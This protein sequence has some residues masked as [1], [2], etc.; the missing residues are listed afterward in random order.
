MRSLNAMLK[1]L[2]DTLLELTSNAVFAGD[3][4]ADFVHGLS[5]PDPVSSDPA[6]YH[7]GTF[8]HTDGSRYLMVVNRRCRSSD[9]RT[10]TV[11]LDARQLSGT[12][13]VYRMTDVYNN[14][15]V[16]ASLGT[17]GW[18]HSFSVSLDPGAGKLYRI[19]PMQLPSA[20]QNLTVAEVGDGTVTLRWD[21]PDN[22]TIDDWQ[23]RQNDGGWEGM[24]DD[25]NTYVYDDPTNTYIYTVMDLTN[26]T[27]YTFEVQAHNA[28]GWGPASASVTATPA[29]MPDAPVVSA[30]ARDGEVALNIRLTEEN[31]AAITRIEW[32]ISHINGVE[33]PQPWRS[34]TIDPSSGYYPLLFTSGYTTTWKELTNGTRYTFEARAVNAAGEG[35]P[36]RL[37]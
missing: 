12:D 11:T 1:E 29:G 7:L 15:S 33:D 20:P 30:E 18:D 32:Q 8:T 10:V 4:P 35:R 17:N 21:N 36:R 26:G 16:T 6:D 23:Y 28:A 13:Y 9:S 14:E 34:H 25:A 3:A 31:G 22:A 24:S 2:D 27:T 19:E 5:D 37:R